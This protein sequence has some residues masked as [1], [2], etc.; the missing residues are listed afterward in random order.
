MFQGLKNSLKIQNISTKLNLY[1]EIILAFAL[2]S[3]ATGQQDKYLPT[4]G[5]C[6]FEVK[7]LAMSA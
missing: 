6:I 4:I 2:D 7:F 5:H 3:S 1:R